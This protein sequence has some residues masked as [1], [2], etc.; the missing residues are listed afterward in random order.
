MP[1]TQVQQKTPYNCTCIRELWL[2]LQIFIDSLS[3]RMKSKVLYNF[4]W[5]F[6]YLFVFIL[7]VFIFIV[8]LGV[9]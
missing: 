1:L 3:D 7:L 2:M 4:V 8:F 5:M 9:Y 6:L